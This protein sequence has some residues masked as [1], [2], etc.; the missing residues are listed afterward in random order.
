VI[1]RLLFLITLSSCGGS[2]SHK[3]IDAAAST[4]AVAI[5]GPTAVDGAA[6]V[7]SVP[8]IDGASAIDGTSAVDAPVLPTIDAG[9]C[10]VEGAPCATTMCVDSVP[11][12]TSGATACTGTLTQICTSYVCM[13]GVCTAQPPTFPVV[14][15]D[16]PDGY[17]CGTTGSGCVAGQHHDECCTAGTCSM[18][19]GSCMP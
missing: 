1:R 8:A 3:A 15:C 7:D 2:S 12:M 19:C 14:A 4:D 16:M 5:D 6:T 11:C 13:S 10:S 9:P 18:V 17:G